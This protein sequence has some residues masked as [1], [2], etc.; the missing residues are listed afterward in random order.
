[1]A[2]NDH[3][4]TRRQRQGG[5]LAG[6]SAGELIYALSIAVQTGATVADLQHARAVHPTLAEAIS[7][8]AAS[9]ETVE[10]GA[11]LQG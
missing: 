1:V 11:G 4:A 3:P 10:P 5:H 8:A 9:P 2:A 6:P 7:W